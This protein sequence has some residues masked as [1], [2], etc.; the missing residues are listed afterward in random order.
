M[1]T[2][3]IN[4]SPRVTRIPKQEIERCQP[5][6]WSPEKTTSPQDWPCFQFL[7]LWVHIVHFGVFLLSILFLWFIHFIACRIFYLLSLQYTTSWYI[8]LHLGYYQFMKSGTYLWFCKHSYLWG[9]L[10]GIE[11]L[12]IGYWQFSEMIA[13][14]LYSEWWCLRVLITQFLNNNTYSLS[15]SF[16]PFWWVCTLM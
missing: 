16:Q 5:P 7:T 14:Q 10:L 15:F 6:E 1:H 3:K 11:L 2:H 12:I 9:L 4:I 13:L 8:Y